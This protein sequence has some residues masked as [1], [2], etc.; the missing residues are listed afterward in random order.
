LHSGSVQ[1]PRPGGPGLNLSV[2]KIFLNVAE[3]IGS[4]DSA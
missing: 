3:L 2:A 4:K 1:A